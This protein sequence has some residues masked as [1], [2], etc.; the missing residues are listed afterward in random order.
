MHAMYLPAAVFYN[1]VEDVRIRI[2]KGLRLAEEFAKDNRPD[3]DMKLAKLRDKYRDSMRTGIL[4]Q[5]GGF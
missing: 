3:N 2:N 1:F 5:Q 4:E